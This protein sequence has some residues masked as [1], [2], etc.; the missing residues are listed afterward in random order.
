[1]KILVTGGM[2]FIGSHTVIE[3]FNAGFEPIII[4][5]LE[6]SNADVLVGLERIAGK[7]FPFYKGDCRDSQ[8]LR[9]IFAEHKPNAVIHF[10]AYKA[11]GESVEQPLK[12]YH[13]NINALL[14][15]LEVMAEFDC[16]H[17]VFS[18]SCT[19]Y[20]QPSMNPVSEAALTGAASSPYGYSKV[21]C[22][23]ILQDYVQ[24]NENISAVLLRYF[25]PVG[26]HP[27]AE[28]GELPNGVPNNLIPY[29]TQTGAGIRKQLT[30]HGNDYNTPDGTCIRDFIHVVDLAIAHVRALEWMLKN[31]VH[32]EIFNLGQ[33]QGN[34]VLEMVK[35]FEA[36]TG[37]T[38]PYIIGPRR[39]GDVEQIWAD[40]SKATTMLGWKTERTIE[41]ALKDAWKWQLRLSEKQKIKT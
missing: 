1:M 22:E 21:V 9:E 6:N 18:S 23:R 33:G 24:A 12:Y 3:L 26:A 28:I 32:T 35:T 10:A 39:A 27:S 5:T 19:V 11:V 30:I 14:T 2:G 16:R 13:N 4:D 34:S 37:E 20:G 15:V 38:L 7:R 25:N 40:V 31:K 29:I 36:V 8:L 17:I 41:D